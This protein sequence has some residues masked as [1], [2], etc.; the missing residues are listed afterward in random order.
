MALSKLAGRLSLAAL[1]SAAALVL[2]ASA[3]LAQAPIKIGAFLAITGPASFL[4]DPEQKTLEMY[5]EKIN[6]AGGVAGRKGEA[7]HR[8][9]AGLGAPDGRHRVVGR[10][11]RDAV[12]RQGLDGGAVLACHGLD[13][14]HELLVL[15]LRVVDERDRG[16][17]DARQQCD[18]ARVVHAEFDDGGATPARW[19]R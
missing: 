18:L 16:R 7:Q 13:A 8:A 19:W 15:A 10:K 1:A 17:R 3:A 12:G 9:R 4:G 5:I 6:A 14:V 11:D 2:G